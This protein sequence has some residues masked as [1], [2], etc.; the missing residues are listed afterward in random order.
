MFGKLVDMFK[1]TIILALL[2]AGVL[3]LPFAIMALAILAV[4]FIIY[5]ILHDRRLAKE[6]KKHD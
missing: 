3:V 5:A 4:G 6:T 1:V 2:I